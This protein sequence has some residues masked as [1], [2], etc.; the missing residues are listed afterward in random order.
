MKDYYALAGVFA[1]TETF[2]G[3]AVS[4]ANRVGGEPLPLP[5][6]AGHVVLH[7]SIS[8]NKV[9]ELNAELAALQ[10]RKKEAISLTEALGIFWKS[11]GIRGQLSKVSE[12]GEAL[13]LAMGVLDRDQVIDVPLLHRGE[14]G[15]PGE[16]V[17][18]AFPGAIEF[19][20]PIAI[21]S[22]QSGRLEFAQWLTHPQHP[23]TSRV[24]VNRIWSHLFGAGLVRSMDNFGTTGESPSH[25]ELLDYLAVQFMQN[26]WSIKQ[27]VRELTLSRT[28]RQA[29]DYK[30][31]AFLRDPDNRLL[32]RASKRRLQAEAIRD[33]MLAASGEL[34]L[35]RPGGSLV[36]R[37]IGDRPMSLIGLDQRLPPDLDGSMH[38]S[39]YLP[40]IRDRLPDVLDLFDFAEPSLVSGQRETTNV[41]TQALYLM[42]SVFVQDRA[43]AFAARLIND[44]DSDKDRIRLAFQWCYNRLPD[45]TEELRSIQFLAAMRSSNDEEDD[46]AAPKAWTAFAQAL[47]STAEFRNLD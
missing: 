17:P 44:T 29:S 36:G 38:R 47:L 15:K 9:A 25:P 33:A 3:T 31:V 43:E 16:R 24:M 6:G 14:I 32:W 22:D 35:T 19:E 5:V 21:P 13:P 10:E 42:N 27:I 45:V 1:S 41:P 37:V 46:A 2:F 30:E 34:D 7:A 28:Y 11:G 23:L 40:V 4:P 26:G 39:V 18:R 20:T 12:A 8:A